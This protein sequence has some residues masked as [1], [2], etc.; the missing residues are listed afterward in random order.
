MCCEYA[1]K[2]L[3]PKEEWDHVHIE[4]QDS[5]IRTTGMFSKTKGVV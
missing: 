1:R 2:P 4:Q 3:K 5:N